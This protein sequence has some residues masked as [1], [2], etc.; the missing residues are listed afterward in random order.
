MP[1]REICPVEQRAEFII[2]CLRSELPMSALCRK[3]EI[4]RK[5]GYLMVDASSAGP[6]SSAI[7]ATRPV[8]S[9]A[10]AEEIVTMLVSAA[11]RTRP[12]ARASWS[13]GWRTATPAAAAIP[14]HRRDDPQAPR[15][16][17]S[18]A[19]A[20]AGNALRGAVSGL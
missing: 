9:D 17:P 19:R 12:G 5:T 7:A 3:Y 10:T 13:A 1:W 8:P 4:S 15:N 6:R 16:V 20:S 14:E 18:A 2:E 11:R